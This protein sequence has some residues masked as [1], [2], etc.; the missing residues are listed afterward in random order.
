MPLV[1]K[2][3]SSD[4]DRFSRDEIFRRA[5][6]D[7]VWWMETGCGWKL[8]ERQQEIARALV[9]YKRVAVPAAFGVGKTWVSAALVLWW[10]Y[11]HYPSKVI[12]TA[13]TARQVKDLLWS[14]IRT[15]HKKSLR[16]LGGEPLKLQLTLE[17]EW[18]A[19][20]FSTDEE[21][22]DK[23]TGYH[24]PYLLLIFDQAAGIPRSLW[25]A[26]EGLVVGT[27]CRWLAISNTTDSGSAM[28]D[29]CIPGRKSEFGDWHVIK[30]NAF[31][32][33]NIKAG[34]DVIPG[35]I[36]HNWINERRKVWRVTDPLWRIFVEAEFVEETSMTVLTNAHIASMLRSNDLPEPD[37]SD[38]HISIDVADEGEDSTVW[39]VRAGSRVLFYEQVY[40]NNTMEIVDKTVEIIGRIEEQ[41]KSAVQTIKVDSIGVGAGVVSRL[42]QLGY[43]AIPINVSRIPDDADRKDQFLNLRAAMAWSLRDLAEADAVHLHPYYSTPDKFLQDLE[44]ELTLRYRV[45][46]QSG[47]IQLEPK[48]VTKKRLRRSPDFWDA[49]MLCF[50]DYESEFAVSVVP[51]GKEDGS[52]QKEE[53][54]LMDAKMWG[55]TPL[56][57]NDFIEVD[58]DDLGSP[59]EYPLHY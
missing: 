26:A 47:K 37:F 39:C 11:N 6:T 1:K 40:G 56:E 22:I 19:A 36:G 41:T 38:I 3:S 53:Y 13:P 21:N 9:D 16:R 5:Q 24:S 2:A 52:P 55:K 14:E 33:P 7:P 17:D 48:K 15:L 42:G 20:G 45:L 57:E 35:I 43:P 51:A 27:N 25:R 30:I 29:I 23:F 18:F 58:M 49:T 4:L 32:S 12:T 28:A 59:L 8:W 44:E 10:L 54:T 31:D 34:K 46:P 50:G